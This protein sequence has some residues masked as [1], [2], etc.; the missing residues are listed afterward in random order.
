MNNMM[1]SRKDHQQN[2]FD[3]Q[4]SSWDTNRGWGTNSSNGENPV[5]KN[6][7]HLRLYRT[8]RKEGLSSKEAKNTMYLLTGT[9]SDG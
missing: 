5:F 4:P 8:L 6:R 7:E 1:R 9:K 3:S 2:I